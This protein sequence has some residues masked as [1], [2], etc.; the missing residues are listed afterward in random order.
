MISGRTGI[1]DGACCPLAVCIQ[2]YQ[3]HQQLNALTTLLN[4][5]SARHHWVI[6]G[7]NQGRGHAHWSWDW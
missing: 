6:S 4:E 3:Y 2:F 5:N 7:M 1:P